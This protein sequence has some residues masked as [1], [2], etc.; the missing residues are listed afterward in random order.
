MRVY[1]CVRACVR[2]CVRSCVHLCVCEC[3]CVR[4]GVIEPLTSSG[5]GGCKGAA[6]AEAA[7]R[8][9]SDALLRMES[10]YGCTADFEGGCC[11]SSSSRWRSCAMPCSTTGRRAARTR[12]MPAA[13]APCRRHHSHCRRF[14]HGSNRACR[15]LHPPT[16]MTACTTPA[17]SLRLILPPPPPLLSPTPLRLLLPLLPHQ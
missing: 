14:Q 7:G 16:R 15:L 9:V 3:A 13:A 4:T 5:C 1:V 17:L 11:W 10:G 2:V 12:P 6:A 8:M